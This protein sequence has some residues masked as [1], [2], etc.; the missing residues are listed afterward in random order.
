LGFGEKAL[1]GSKVQDLYAKGDMKSIAQYC[2]DDV[3]L[4]AR[5]FGAVKESMEV[6]FYDR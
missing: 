2:L 3:I 6:M 4:T 1:D 5:L